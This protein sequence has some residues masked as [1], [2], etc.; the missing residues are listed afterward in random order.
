MNTLAAPAPIAPLTSPGTDGA[1]ALVAAI[2]TE[3]AAQGGRITFARFMELALYHPAHGYY[4]APERRPGRG[5]DFL[6][7][8]ETHP[9]FG[10]A[11]A[12]LL[13]DCWERLERPDPFIVREYGAGV[14]GLAYDLIA[15]LSQTAPAA[16]AALRYRLIEPNPHRRQQ[17]LAAMAEV[18]LADRVTVE[19]PPPGEDPTLEPIVGVVLANEVADALPVHRLVWRGGR[20]DGSL[21]ERYVVWRDEISSAGFVA[22]EG[23]LSPPA[24]RF[25]P[26]ARLREA[27]VRLADGDLLEMSPA[28]AAW[29]GGVARGLARGYVLV[30]DYG[31]ETAELY[32]AHRLR[33]T[34]RGYHQHTVTDDPF[35]RVG[36]Q[37]LTAH[38]DFGALRRAGVA[39]GLLPAG[40]TTQAEFMTALGLG[41]LLVGLQAEPQ[42][43]AEEYLASR[44]AVF[45]L[46]DPGGMGRFGVLAMAR[47]ALVV[48]PLLGF[49]PPTGLVRAGEASGATPLERDEK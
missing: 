42:T 35:R 32:R 1:P 24:R 9:F 38:V 44:A 11:L 18:G 6:T 34:L 21:R 25:E 8:P 10:F 16:A 13:A 39:A 2:R 14:G 20:D 15:G 12:R 7:A 27:G 28:A 26:A 46:I 47:A 49:G 30:I 29:I 23:D 33:G 17:A 19:V 48:P 43:S 22:E 41:D 36:E 31:Y 4:L 3:I 37:D 40:F 45:R 5:G